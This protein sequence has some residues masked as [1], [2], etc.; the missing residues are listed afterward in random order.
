MIR[1]ELPHAS[2]PDGGSSV[3][4]PLSVDAI[5]AVARALLLRG[6]SEAVGMRELARVL[7]V[8]PSALYRHVRD[9]QH[10][11][12]LLAATL[13]AELARAVASARRDARGDDPQD[14][15]RAAARAVPAWAE[16]HPAEFLFMFHTRP[17]PGG[18]SEAFGM[19]A[20]AIFQPEVPTHRHGSRRPVDACHGPISGSRPAVVA[21]RRLLGVVAVDLVGHARWGVT[22]SVEDEVEQ[23]ADALRGTKRGSSAGPVAA[24]S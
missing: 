20:S 3:V 1:D 2:P 19:T 8:V 12:D 9:R 23:L 5:V 13:D 15:N 17:R 24:R 4:L 22:S 10:V 14:R 16:R 11:L 6:G 18:S 21:F 7:G